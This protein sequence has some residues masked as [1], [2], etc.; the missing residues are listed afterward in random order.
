MSVDL[1]ILKSILRF[2]FCLLANNRST[3]LLS[4]INNVNKIYKYVPDDVMLIQTF[5]KK[6]W[7]VSLKQL[8]NT[9]RVRNKCKYDWGKWLCYNITYHLP[10]FNIRY[11][12]ISNLV[13]L[14]VSSLNMLK[15][16]KNRIPL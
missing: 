9:I 15:L 10:G 11:S 2:I 4:Q 7:R 12:I 8:N 6:N 16:Q 14:L 5:N 13:S 1:V 3:K